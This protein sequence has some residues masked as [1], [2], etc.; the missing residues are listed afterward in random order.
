MGNTEIRQILW[1]SKNGGKVHGQSQRI[2]RPVELP[3]GKKD[4]RDAENA[5]CFNLSKQRCCIAFS[6]SSFVSKSLGRK[7]VLAFCA[8]FVQWLREWSPGKPEWAGGGAISSI[9][10]H[11]VSFTG[12]YFLFI[13]RMRDMDTFF[14]CTMLIFFLFFPPLCSSSSAFPTNITDGVIFLSLCCW[15]WDT[16]IRKSASF[17]LFI[18]FLCKYSIH[19][20][21]FIENGEGKHTFNDTINLMFCIN[22]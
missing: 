16:L 19:F 2:S 7:E 8:A 1:A 15:F 20:M 6:P 5:T 10:C 21:L 11:G 22:N 13:C 14:H 4:G 17:R 9:G 18:L 3:L 12:V